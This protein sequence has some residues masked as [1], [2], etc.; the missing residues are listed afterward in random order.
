MQ[1]PSRKSY[2]SIIGAVSFLLL[3]IGLAGLRYFGSPII[4]VIFCVGIC[5]ILFVQAEIYRR[6]TVIYNKREQ[7][8]KQVEALLSLHSLIPTGY[9]LPPM[10]DGA[11]S[12]DLA[13]IL[14]KIIKE[15]KPKNILECGSGIS[16]LI[17]AYCLKDLGEGH[18]WS[19]EHDKNYAD[20][21]G[22]NLKKHK[23]EDRASVI[24]APLK[25]M[26]IREKSWLWYDT[27]FL[28]KIEKIDLLLIDGPPENIREMARYPSLPLLA[29]SLSE[30]A[31]IVVDDASR[32]DEKA[33][34]DLWLK[35]FK[36]FQY[37]FNK[38][39]KGTVILKKINGTITK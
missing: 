32:R 26:S 18:I 19:L 14:I 1:T 31:V 30:S 12:P 34:V 4:I 13:V 11:I 20:I 27:E 29:G 22:E 28:N 3:V 38:T 15:R 35:E 23:L 21:T 6:L 37:D 2:I 25:E 33:M 39:E 24:F 7:D 8:Y 17:M 16:T 36:N 9:P 10:R 5:L